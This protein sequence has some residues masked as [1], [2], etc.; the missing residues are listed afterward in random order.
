MARLGSA[1]LGCIQPIAFKEFGHAFPAVDPVF[2]TELQL[3]RP[4]LGL[5]FGFITDASDTGLGAVLA[6][7]DEGEK[8]KV[9]A[10][11][12]RRLSA[13]ERNY[14]TTEKECLAVV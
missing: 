2:P 1:W 6:Q 3:L 7:D 9:I 12:A 13:S 8:E 10:Y 14:P 5:D 11:E 4:S